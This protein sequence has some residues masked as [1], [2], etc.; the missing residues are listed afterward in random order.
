MPGTGQF[1]ERVR[2]K[3]LDL[4]S[5]GLR[6]TLQPPAGI[7]LSSNDYLGLSQHPIIKQRMAEAVLEE[8]CGSTASRLL[9]GE[10]SNLA[11]VERRFAAFKGTEAA[12]FFGSGYTANL[13]VLA[14]FVERHDT[15]FTDAQNHASIVDG[16]RLSRAKRMKFR[17]CDVDDLARRLRA[18]P[19]GTQKFLVTESLFSMDGDF[20]PL[21]RYAELC[22]ETG[23]VL[24]VDE[25][26]AVGIYGE[27]GS[28]WIEHTGTGSEVFVS[29]DTA[30]KALGVAGAFV[31]GP[32]W[33]IDYLIQRARPFIFS[34]APP[35]ALAAALDA[36]LLVSGNEPGRRQRV[37]ELSLK[38]R[39]MFA[40]YGLNIG[41]SESQIIPLILGENE[42]ARAVAADLQ[43]EGFDVRAVRPPAVPPG[44]ARLRISV[45]AQLDEA[46]LQGFASAAHRT[47]LCS[48][49]SS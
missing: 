24:I 21:A 37:Q 8:G 42:R 31:C 36:S 27:R 13:S 46:T 33:A 3:I 30:G 11:A 20:A 48:T 18:A 39:G 35:P 7:D 1:E 5:A 17:H 2:R 45:N 15:I 4:E 25:A 14:T 12:L 38:L 44:T 34:T 9:R 29:V 16:I 26:H 10:R 40:E 41:R 28:G 47:I 19:Q 43:R 49:A 6:R 32:G 22:R 23:T